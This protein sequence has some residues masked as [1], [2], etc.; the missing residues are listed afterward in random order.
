MP[1]STR[2]LSKAH[3]RC[4]IMPAW[5]PINDW[6]NVLAANPL[7]TPLID[8]G[9]QNPVMRIGVTGLNWFLMDM[10]GLRGKWYSEGWQLRDELWLLINPMRY[11]LLGHQPRQPYPEDVRAYL[12]KTSPHTLHQT[13][14]EHAY[15]AIAPVVNRFT[16]DDAEAEA[17]ASIAPWNRIAI[18]DLSKQIIGMVWSPGAITGNPPPIFKPYYSQKPKPHE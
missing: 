15:F 10:L 9:E 11:R 7:A 13:L 17:M 8:F 14:A 6:L 2:L 3:N 4:L 12:A 5:T 16:L 1:I 18:V